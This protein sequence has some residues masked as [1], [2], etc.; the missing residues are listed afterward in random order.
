MRA[1]AALSFS[2]LAGCNGELADLSLPA[3]S[4]PSF[5]G[6]A[7]RIDVFGGR[8]VV[9]GPSGFCADRRASRPSTGFAVLGDCSLLGGGEGSTR[10]AVITVQVGEAASAFVT[11]SE[12]DLR[13]LINTNS[14]AVLRDGAT[15]ISSETRP[16]AVLIQVD[17]PVPQAL[18]SVES[19]RWRAIADVEG[20]L[21]T[22]TVY[23]LAASPL[24]VDQ[25]RTLL[26]QS[27][28]NL[29]QNNSL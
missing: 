27:L 23:G 22:V 14:A 7:D 12:D 6:A 19:N 1:A 8:F 26:L 3:L 15:V 9:V 13:R 2:I 28:E 17:G 16:G 24:S 11:G 4:L 21:V 5:G 18:G 20:R 29:I 10:P 25:G